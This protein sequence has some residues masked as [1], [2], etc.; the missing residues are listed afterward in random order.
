MANS[1]KDE[2]V[3]VMDP[4]FTVASSPS[5]DHHEELFQTENK[6]AMRSRVRVKKKRERNMAFPS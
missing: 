4:L 1:S 6:G 2:E 3:N 5:A